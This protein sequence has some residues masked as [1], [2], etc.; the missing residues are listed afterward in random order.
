MS[1]WT[2]LR[3]TFSLLPTLRVSCLLGI[4][5]GFTRSEEEYVFWWGPGIVILRTQEGV[6]PDGWMIGGDIAVGVCYCM[7]CYVC[8][9][10]CPWKH[11]PIASLSPVKCC[12]VHWHHSCTDQFL[13]CMVLALVGMDCE[14]NPSLL[15]KSNKCR[16]A[17]CVFSKFQITSMYL[18]SSENLFTYL[19]RP[20]YSL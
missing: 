12:S 5:M 9:H 20:L 3:G 1:M 14:G 17:Q 4:G 10:L 15:W 13:K 16:W 18:H 8:S 6:Y 19:M 7:F 2:S 11:C